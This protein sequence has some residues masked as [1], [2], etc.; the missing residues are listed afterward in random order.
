MRLFAV[1]VA[2]LFAEQ[3][4]RL[5]PRIAALL[6]AGG[7]AI[8]SG[9]RVE[10]AAKVREA[11]T[12]AG[13]VAEAETEEDGWVTVGFLGP[14]APPERLAPGMRLLSDQIVHIKSA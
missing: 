4:I 1:V 6:E 11:W 5:A 13:L 3:L 12:A 14:Q 2:N 8:G 7:T 10:E 9:I